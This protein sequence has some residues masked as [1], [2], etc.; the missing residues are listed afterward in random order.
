MNGNLYDIAIGLAQRQAPKRKYT[1]FA[2]RRVGLASNLNEQKRP[3][4]YYMQK[5]SASSTS[6]P[7]QAQRPSD[8]NVHVDANKDSDDA[9]LVN[10]NPFDNPDS[11]LSSITMNTLYSNRAS[12][13]SDS[14]GKH[15]FSS[16]EEGPSADEGHR[17]AETGLCPTERCGAAKRPAQDPASARSGSA[18]GPHLD[19]I[20]K[21]AGFSSINENDVDDDGQLRSSIS[22][23]TLHDPSV[24]ASDLTMEPPRLLKIVRPKI[25][26]ASTPN[27][28]DPKHPPKLS[29]QVSETLSYILTRSKTRFYNAKESKERKELRKKVYEESNDDEILGNDLDLAFNVP[30]VK[31]NGAAYRSSKPSSSSLHSW[32]DISESGIGKYPNTSVASIN[33]CPLPGK[34]SHSRLN[35][36]NASPATAD[37][38]I[39]E[40]DAVNHSSFH[41]IDNDSEICNNISEFYT[42]RSLSYSQVAK[43]TRDQTVTHKLPNYVKSQTSQEELSLVSPEKL[44]VLDQTRPI[45]LPPK[46]AHDKAKHGKEM[47]KV[48]TDLE[49]ATKNQTLSRQTLNE[50]YITNQQTWFRLMIDT[51]EKAF[52][53]KLHSDKNKLRA[54]SWES[55]ISEKYRF[56]YFMRVLR[57]DLPSDFVEKVHNSLPQL[58]AKYHSLSPQVRSVKDSQF[59]QVVDSVLCRPLFLNYL[60]DTG[61]IQNP[62]DD[63]HALRENFLHLLYLKSFSEGGLKR[64]HELFVIPIFLVLFQSSQTLHNIYVLMEMFEASVFDLDMFAS[65]NKKLAC[66]KDLSLLSSSSTQYKIL[67]RFTSLDEF[68]GLNSSTLFELIIQL[69]DKL[70]L[71]HSAPSTP[72]VA[73]NAF[74]S[75]SKASLDSESSLGSQTKPVD[76]ASALESSTLRSSSMSLVGMFLQ[77]IVIYSRSRYRKHNLS[78]LYQAFLL[79]IFKFYHINWNSSVELVQRNKSIKL[80]NSSDQLTNLESFLDKWHDIFKKL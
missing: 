8:S 38:M 27:V 77:L 31:D 67:K 59:N 63:G 68:E 14:D 44:E 20:A 64:H 16:I 6:L 40:D 1:G 36:S 72:V 32:E 53:H 15:G 28:T 70:P 47:L 51:D 57:Q 71:S 56:E 23:L 12:E 33:P 2:P 45:N 78:K 10:S 74:A 46:T 11:R 29:R 80:N 34:L 9:S 39:P 54:L 55:P 37:S 19:N 30:V 62:D 17:L 76:T 22:T 43:A 65:L 4:E 35:L 48:L 41:S 60:S 25:R 61:T 13:A 49:V 21:E 73:Q 3:N 50:H 79:T 58:D 5:I 24:S 69:N 42:Q 75:L 18:A 26:A 52:K 7:K 66:W